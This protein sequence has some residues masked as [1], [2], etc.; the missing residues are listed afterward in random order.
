MRRG[1]V[2]ALRRE[3]YTKTAIAAKL[4]VSR[5]TIDRDFL[6]LMAYGRAPI[7]PTCGRANALPRAWFTG[8]MAP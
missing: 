2:M 4:H 3:G 8:G 7:C 6:A 1:E 5:R